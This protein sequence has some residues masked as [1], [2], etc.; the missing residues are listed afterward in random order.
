LTSK[1][2]GNNAKILEFTN[3]A[4]SAKLHKKCKKENSAKSPAISDDDVQ[5]GYQPNQRTRLALL[6]SLKTRGGDENPTDKTPK[7]ESGKIEEVK[8]SKEER[9]AE[10]AEM[11]TCLLCDSKNTPSSFQKLHSKCNHKICNPCI[12]KLIK[13]HYHKYR[14]RNHV[15]CPYDYK[16]ISPSV[17]A[18]V[19]P[20]VHSYGHSGMDGDIFSNVFYPRTYLDHSAFASRIH[21]MR[22]QF[23]DPYEV[24]GRREDEDKEMECP[25]CM[26]KTKKGNEVFTKRDVARCSNCQYCFYFCCSVKISTVEAHGRHYHRVGC[27]NY[28]V[29]YIGEEEMKLNCPECKKIGRLCDRP[30]DIPRGIDLVLLP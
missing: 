24:P 29:N 16:D 18:S 1:S 19:G 27:R 7:E 4:V 3:V 2:L 17:I 12:K 13:M 8:M 14:H 23:I 25:H 5:V 21:A 28:A 22:Y 11:S 30:C 10:I 26:A 20:V 6:P 15:Q 9:E